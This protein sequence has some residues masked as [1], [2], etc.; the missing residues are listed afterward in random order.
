MKTSGSSFT[1]WFHLA[2]RAKVVKRSLKVALIVGT[3]LVMINQLDIFLS[4]QLAL[5]NYI[6]ILLTYC[7][8]YCVSTYASV[9]TMMNRENK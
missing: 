2:T 9:D 3:I 4:G 5:G 1:H 6:Q 8:P 7:V